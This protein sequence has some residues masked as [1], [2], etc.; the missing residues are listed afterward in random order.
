MNALGCSTAQCCFDFVQ[1]SQEIWRFM[2]RDGQE[3]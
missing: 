2:A 1:S 3:D